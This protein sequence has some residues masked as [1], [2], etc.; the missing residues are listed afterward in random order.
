MTAYLQK[1]AVP[2]DAWW[3]PLVLAD[4]CA[5]A[6]ESARTPFGPHSPEKSEGPAAFRSPQMKPVN[7]EYA[8][9][10]HVSAPNI[11]PKGDAGRKTGSFTTFFFTLA[12]QLTILVPG[13]FNH[14]SNV[15]F[16]FAG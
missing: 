1:L 5:G 10:G 9:I 6:L 13:S 11:Q 12:T 7:C 8:S 15:H 4:D 2:V 14:N 16:F 3:V